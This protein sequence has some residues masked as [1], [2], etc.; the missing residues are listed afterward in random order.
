MDNTKLLRGVL[1]SLY[2][3]Q[4]MGITGNETRAIFEKLKTIKKKSVTPSVKAKE[5]VDV[6][7]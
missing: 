4:K 6:I 3:E 7:I 2:D 5:F 1:R